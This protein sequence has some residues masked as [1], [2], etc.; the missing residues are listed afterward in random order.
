[1][2]S[3]CLL[4]EDEKDL[5]DI[6]ADQLS[7]EGIE[8]RKAYDAE[9]A[10]RKAREEQPGLIVTDVRMPG[11]NGLEFV[12]QFL[13]DVD[14]KSSSIKTEIFVMT[15]FCDPETEALLEK[16]HGEH[17]SELFLKPGDLKKLSEKVISYFKA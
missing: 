15:G 14:V 3:Y 13:Q 16:Y 1:M 12:M 5:C 9:Q 7:Q 6:L 11:M 10:S 2:N 4:V 8:V 17:F